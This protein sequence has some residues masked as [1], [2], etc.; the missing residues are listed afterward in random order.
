LLVERP[1]AIL[2]WS[3]GLTQ[4]AHGVDTIRALVNVGLARGLPGH[5]NRG[6]VPIRGHSGVQGGAEV[7]CVPT[8]DRATRAR[9]AEVWGFDPPA[10]DGWTAAEMIAQ[11]AGGG[12]DVFWIIGGN[13]LETLPGEA[14]SRRAL[15]RPSLRIHHDIVVSS[16]MLV[17]SEGDVVLLP[18][19]TRYESEGGGT[20]TS[21]ERRIIFS[22]EIPGRRIGSARPE[23]RVLGDVMARVRPE[24]AER[25]RF[26]SAAAIRE[27]IA[28]AIPLYRGIEALGAK[29]DQVQWGGR[30]LYEDGRFAT[31]DGKAHFSGVSLGTGRQLTPRDGAVF[32]MSTRRGKQFNSMVQRDRDPL[33]G[34]K[35]D[36]VLISAEDLERLNLH[37]G[38]SVELTPGDGPAAAGA[39]RGRLKVAAMTPGN[40][41]VHWPEGN[42]LLQGSAIDPDS[43][44]PDYNA[45]VRMVA[46]PVLPAS[47]AP[48]GLP[49]SPG[50]SQPSR[51]SSLAA[52]A[53][54]ASVTP[55]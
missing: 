35:R 6:L 45:L 10:A 46:A 34:A 36:D 42:V 26:T 48:P 30:V 39:F 22:P 28:R 54:D 1:N 11:A 23:W 2:V 24:R 13:F 5:P 29:G 7:G 25:I 14:R 40:I 43:L 3:M 15:A 38:D 53:L 33:T 55:K 4:H 8:I 16:S 47:P 41:E 21:T 31:A 49:S 32:R 27:E 12:V 37:E 50:R 18:A 51:S 19:V 9:W 52:S 20:E 44:E 17:E